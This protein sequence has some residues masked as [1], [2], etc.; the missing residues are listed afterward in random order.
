MDH[1]AGITIENA[2]FHDQWMCLSRGDAL[3][4]TEKDWTPCFERVY[5]ADE[6]YFATVLAASG[7]PPLDATANRPITWTDW[8]GG[9]H[10][11]EFVKVLP[12]D[13]A[14]IAESG[15]FFARKFSP[16]SNIGD[17]RLHLI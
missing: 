17:Y 9:A 11:Q 16:S 10:P 7:K 12:R 8:R 2:Y 1:L 5:I 4:V 3:T 6:C 13:A 14:R 15:C